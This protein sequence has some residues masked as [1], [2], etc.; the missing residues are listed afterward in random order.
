MSECVSYNFKFVVNRRTTLANFANQA[1][2]ATIRM[3]SNFSLIE[4]LKLD[5]SIVEIPS[6]N[7]GNA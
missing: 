6:L 2:Q 1:N 5:L 7:R 3:I 4:R